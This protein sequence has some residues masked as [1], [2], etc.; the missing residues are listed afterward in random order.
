MLSDI[1][2]EGT[3]RLPEFGG[4]SPVVLP[5]QLTHGVDDT[6]SRHVDIAEDNHVCSVGLS[7]RYEISPLLPANDHRDCN[8]QVHGELIIEY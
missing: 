5:A 6:V 8:S 1:F 3:P 2:Y 7:F 4:C